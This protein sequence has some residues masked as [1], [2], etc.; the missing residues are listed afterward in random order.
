LVNL[1]GIAIKFTEQ[2]EVVVRAFLTEEDESGCVICF[3]VSDTGVGIDP[4]YQDR[5]FDSFTQADA[6]TTRRYG[7]SGLGLAISKQLAELM[8]G[9]IGVKSV[10]GSGSTF[11]F[12]VRLSRANELEPAEPENGIE[13]VGLP[14]LVVD[15]NATNRAMLE[16]NLAKWESGHRVFR[17]EARRSCCCEM[18]RGAVSRSQSPCWTTRCQKW[19]GL[20]SRVP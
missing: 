4:E 10:K 19:T 8:G 13:V 2:G 9:K 16:L 14:A 11:W 20:I 6:S 1:A 17:A 12:T 15:D 18:H 7:G 3:E 5:L